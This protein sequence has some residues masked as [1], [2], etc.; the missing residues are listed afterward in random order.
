MPSHDEIVRGE[1]GKQAESFEDPRYLFADRRLTRWILAHV[2]PEPGALVLDVAGGT[3]HV[4]RAYADTA[5]LAVV[6]DLTH[7]MLAAGKREA[8]GAGLRNLL[9]VLGDAARMPFLDDSFDLV[10]SRFAVHHFARP[11]DQIA[12][13]ARVCGRGGRVA[14]I[15]LIAADEPLARKQN[16]LERMRDPSHTRALSV[17]ELAELLERAGTAVVHQT[18]RD[19]VLPVERWLSQAQTANE[20]AEGIR[21]ELQAEL[22]GGEATGLRPVIHEEALHFTQRWAILVAQKA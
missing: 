17:P 3:G 18:T 6:I 20:T 19:Q 4:A 2:P 11:A 5:A 8:E 12:E 7:E 22:E 9:F 21:R 1:F 14:I 16:L 15:D 10:V 13:M